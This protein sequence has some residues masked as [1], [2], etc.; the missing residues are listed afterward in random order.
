MVGVTACHNN[1]TTAGLPPTLDPLLNNSNNDTRD[2]SFDSLHNNNTTNGTRRGPIYRMWILARNY[3]LTDILSIAA[4][5]MI[6][7]HSAALVA[8]T[9]KISCI[10]DRIE[11]CHPLNGMA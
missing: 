6:I 1:T 11:C 9:F 10:I 2:S 8:V 5:V 7:T 3:E 4:C